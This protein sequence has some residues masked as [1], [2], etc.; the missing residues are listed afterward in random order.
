M[1]IY[2]SILVASTLDIVTCGFGLGVI[3]GADVLSTVQIKTVTDKTQ[4]QPISQKTETQ[5]VTDKT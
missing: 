4:T 2:L 1:H 3:K 5:P